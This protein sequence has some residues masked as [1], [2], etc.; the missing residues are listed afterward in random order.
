[1]KEKL[2]FCQVYPLFS[3]QRLTAVK[4]GKKVIIR[5]VGRRFKPAK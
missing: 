3:N 2:C 4:V 1:M 5:I